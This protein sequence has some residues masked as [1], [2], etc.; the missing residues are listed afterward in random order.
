MEELDLSKAFDEV[1]KS[2][3]TPK[4]EALETATEAANLDL[5]AGRAGLVQWP[6]S[7]LPVGG[8]VRFAQSGFVRE[9]LGV[10]SRHPAKAR[11]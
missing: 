7:L 9:V 5:A 2:R 3:H 1:L 10:S 11:T 4:G 6:Q 8:G